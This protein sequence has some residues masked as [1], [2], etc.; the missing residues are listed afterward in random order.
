MSSKVLLKNVVKLMMVCFYHG[1][2][3]TTTSKTIKVGTITV[4]FCPKSICCKTI[5]RLRGKS[6]VKVSVRSRFCRFHGCIFRGNVEI[7]IPFVCSFHGYRWLENTFGLI[8]T[9]YCEKDVIFYINHLFFPYPRAAPVQST[10]VKSCPGS[11]RGLVD[12]S[13][14]PHKANA[15]TIGSIWTTPNGK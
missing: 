9:K 10:C 4:S 1:N 15:I 12:P 3:N 6:K 11:D 7:K 13:H 8:L 5:V 2:F 14:F